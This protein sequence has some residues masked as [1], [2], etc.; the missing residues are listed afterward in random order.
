[1]KFKQ[2]HQ[3]LAR[4]MCG[5]TNSNTI[6]T[7]MNLLKHSP[8]T[9]HI[10]CVYICASHV[11]AEANESCACFCFCFR[12]PRCSYNALKSDTKSLCILLCSTVIG[13]VSRMCWPMRTSVC[14][15]LNELFIIDMTMWVCE[16]FQSIRI[17]KQNENDWPFTTAS[18]ARHSRTLT[19]SLE[20]G[21]IVLLSDFIANTLRLIL[22][23]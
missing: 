3:K 15:L 9:A 18:F 4:E 16:Q 20:W 5:N 2:K 23:L 22:C 7:S 19:N 21:L 13:G 1:M 12:L 17:T 14:P 8:S 10:A 6:F 11:C